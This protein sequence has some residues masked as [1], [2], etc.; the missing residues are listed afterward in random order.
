[1]ICDQCFSVISQL[2][3]MTS[4]LLLFMDATIVADHVIAIEGVVITRARITNGHSQ[5]VIT[6][7]MNQ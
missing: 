4:L 5:R 6:R 2:S 3:L 1:M 7:Q